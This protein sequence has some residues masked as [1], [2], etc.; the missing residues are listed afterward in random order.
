MVDE[1]QQIW[2]SASPVSW[3][4]NKMEVHPEIMNPRSTMMEVSLYSDHNQECNFTREQFLL[5]NEGQRREAT[6]L[7]L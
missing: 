6:Q 5:L 1:I 3:R 4:R 2:S 7:L